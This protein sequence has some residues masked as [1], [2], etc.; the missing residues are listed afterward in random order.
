[1]LARQIN[2]AEKSDDRVY[3]IEYKRYK[4][5]PLFIRVGS[6]QALYT[7]GGSCGLFLVIGVVL[8][9]R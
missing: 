3:V 8:P 9:Q 5:N 4:M 7:G 2:F 1:M 6:S